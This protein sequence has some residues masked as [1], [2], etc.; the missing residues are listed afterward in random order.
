MV[1]SATSRG[2]NVSMRGLYVGIV[3]AYT[4]IRMRTEISALVYCRLYFSSGGA[5]RNGYTC[6]CAHSCCLCNDPRRARGMIWACRTCNSDVEVQSVDMFEARSQKFERDL[7]SSHTRDESVVHDFF[8]I[9]TV[10]LLHA[11]KRRGNRAPTTL[12]M[13]QPATYIERTRGYVS[14]Y[15]RLHEV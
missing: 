14:R 15:M 11:A 4:F 1:M 6:A 12:Q 3:L 10:Q 13:K 2:C 9:Y 5:E 8:C 7:Q